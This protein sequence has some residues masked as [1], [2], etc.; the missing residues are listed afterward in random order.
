MDIDAASNG[1]DFAFVAQ[2]VGIAFILVFTAAT[3]FMFI[4]QWSFADSLYFSLA[5]FSTVGLLILL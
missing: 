4:E 1:T 3:G 5:T 2:C